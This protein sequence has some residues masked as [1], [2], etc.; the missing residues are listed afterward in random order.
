MKRN[1]L[2]YLGNEFC[3]KKGHFL[4]QPDTTVKCYSDKFFGK[5]PFLQRMTILVMHGRQN[6]DNLHRS[7]RSKSCFGGPRP[8]DQENA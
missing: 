8:N 7:V 2:S 1:E 3:I 4:E 6:T 5:Y